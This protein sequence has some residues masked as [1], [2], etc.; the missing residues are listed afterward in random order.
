MDVTGWEASWEVEFPAV[1]VDEILLALVARD[2]VHGASFDVEASEG[3]PRLELD[4][5]AGDE[6]GN[7]I[8]RLVLSARVRGSEDRELVQ[9]V[10]EQVLEEAVD[11]AQA[12]AGSSRELGSRPLSEVTFRVVSEAEERWDLVIPDWYAP[13]G[14]EVPFGFRVFDA[15]SGE[16]WP[17]DD[18]LESQGRVVVV[19][20]G[21]RLRL[22]GVPAPSAAGTDDSALPIHPHGVRGE[23]S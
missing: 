7:G 19:P 5:T 10:T 2:L 14:A 8:Y 18:V 6:L 11:E 12:L 9:R 16:P 22:F 1:S 21:T 13:D 3:G 20:D 17:S 4:F 23:H 15:A